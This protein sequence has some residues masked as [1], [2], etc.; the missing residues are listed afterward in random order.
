MSGWRLASE[1]CLGG[2]QQAPG[3]VVEV[4]AAEMQVVGVAEA[5]AAVES[6]AGSLPG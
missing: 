3:E 1:G 4:A 5:A 2:G 6:T